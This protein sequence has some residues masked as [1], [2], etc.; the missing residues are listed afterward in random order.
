MSR[1]RHRHRRGAQPTTVTLQGGK[2]TNE[3]LPAYCHGHLPQLLIVT[4]FKLIGLANK[5]YDQSPVIASFYMVCF[6]YLSNS[7]ESSTYICR[8]ET[9]SNEVTVIARA[10]SRAKGKA[11]SKSYRARNKQLQNGTAKGSKTDRT[12][13]QRNRPGKKRLATAKGKPFGKDGHC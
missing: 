13:K 6:L 11:L 8:G 4:F 7:S 9:A 12:K 2:A 3:Q 5:V 10:G 1:S